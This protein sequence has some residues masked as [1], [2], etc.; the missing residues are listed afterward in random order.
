MYQIHCQFQIGR[1]RNRFRP[2]IAV[3]FVW[4]IEIV[5][6]SVW[7]LIIPVP[8]TSAVIFLNDWMVMMN[9]RMDSLIILEELTVLMLKFMLCKRDQLFFQ[10]FLCL[11]LKGQLLWESLSCFYLFILFKEF[12]MLNYCSQ[13]GSFSFFF[14]FFKF[15]LVLLFQVVQLLETPFLN[16]INYAS[17]VAT[18]AARHRFVAGE[19][20]MLLE[21]GLR[22]AQ[23]SHTSLGFAKL[24][25]FTFEFFV[26]GRIS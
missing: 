21:F 22:R 5:F 24:T 13:S 7:R 8:K 9:S 18:N 6:I 15:I 12:I 26:W 17:L 3:F 11:E 14:F 2:R 23:V 20:K 19:S 16:L 1:G 10:R 4:G 25:I